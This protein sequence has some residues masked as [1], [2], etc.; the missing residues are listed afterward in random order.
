MRGLSEEGLPQRRNGAE[1]GN[2]RD[3][4]PGWGGKVEG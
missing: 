4:V 2:E 1:A 3:E